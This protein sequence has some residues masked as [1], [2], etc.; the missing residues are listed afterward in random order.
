[1]KNL[2]FSLF[3]FTYLTSYA[4]IESI[5]TD[6][7]DQT[8]SVN[9]VPADW[10]QFEAG[11]N[12]QENEK[13][14]HEYLTPTLLSKYGLNNRVE[15]RLITTL[16]T[17]SYSLILQRTVNKTGLDPVEIG[18]KISLLQEKKWMPKTSFLFH[19]AIPGFA[20]KAND[21]NLVAPNFRFIL[22]K[23]VTENFGI[24]CNLGAEWDGIDGRPAY[25]YTL[26]PGVSF[27]EKWYAY[28]EAFGVFKKRELPEH[29][30]DGGLAYNV[31][32]NLKLDISSGFGIT[33]AAPNWYTAI[34]F[35][36]RFKAGK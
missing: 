31:T 6:R 15:F 21:I 11:F 23:S 9:L 7:P 32:N 18:A 28:I 3:L 5:D 30:I 27:A 29:S 25:I 14:I 34:G 17:N 19:F 20:S 33:K 26:S 36:K 4:Q 22:Q 13:N 1:M 8:E 16:L 35:S 10:F 12:V 24:G 2:T